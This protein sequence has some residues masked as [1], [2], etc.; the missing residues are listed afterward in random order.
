M[1]Q[2]EAGVVGDAS[3]GIDA[4]DGSTAPDAIANNGEGIIMEEGGLE[5]GLDEDNEG[6]QDA[7]ADD[8]GDDGEGAEGSDDEGGELEDL[9]EYSEDKVEE[10]D[11]R[12]RGE[13]GELRLDV[14]TKEWD[15]NAAKAEGGV[16]AL[17]EGTYKYIQD[18]YGLTKAQVQ[19]I[20]AGQVAKRQVF[21]SEV[22]KIVGGGDKLAEMMAWGREA[23][24]PQARKRFNEAYKSGDIERASE[25][26][27][28]LAAR[29]NRAKGNAPRRQANA[30][31]SATSNA[32]GG[33]TPTAGGFATRE[34]WQEA[35]KAAKG[36]PRKEAEVQ[37]KFKRSNIRNWN[38]AK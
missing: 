24:S 1:A 33:Q 18:T 26:V 29:F 34:E 22:S 9:G 32:G 13:N 27:E 37:R 16:G 31:R 15:A 14:L 21:Y 38:K 28:A 11:A 6:T 17:N 4:G 36:D 12:Y 35:R 19:D 23:Y 30:P 10:F 2:N 5:A 7:D 8:M 25:A 3:V 20:E